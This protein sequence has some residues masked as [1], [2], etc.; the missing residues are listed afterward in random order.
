MAHK[1]GATFYGHNT[2]LT[3]AGK[4]GLVEPGYAKS[5][6]PDQLSFSMRIRINNLDQA[7]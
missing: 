7:I 3:P 1:Y 2:T 6:D 4:P 5:V